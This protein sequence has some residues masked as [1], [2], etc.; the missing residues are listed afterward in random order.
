MNDEEART[1][2]KESASL[3]EFQIL[4]HGGVMRSALKCTAKQFHAA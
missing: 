4:W 3:K 2:R 1:T